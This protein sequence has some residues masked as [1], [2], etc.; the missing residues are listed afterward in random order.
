MIAFKMVRTCTHVHHD[1]LGKAMAFTR[2]WNV[3]GKIASQLP[4][5][6]LP[7]RSIDPVISDLEIALAMQPL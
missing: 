3:L 2:A 5:P 6:S 1:Y 7:H 4:R